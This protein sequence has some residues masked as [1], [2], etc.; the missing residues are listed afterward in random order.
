V[1]PPNEVPPEGVVVPPAPTAPPDIAMEPP[2]AGLPL[3]PGEPSGLLHATPRSEAARLPRTL[4]HVALDVART[5]T[6]WIASRDAATAILHGKQVWRAP[7]FSKESN[8]II[9]AMEFCSLDNFP[10]FGTSSHASELSAA[11]ESE[12]VA[13]EHRPSDARISGLLTPTLLRA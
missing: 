1:L 2:A 8:Q 11:R 4:R 9:G 10:S 3:A 13:S 6:K 7:A 12:R 5:M